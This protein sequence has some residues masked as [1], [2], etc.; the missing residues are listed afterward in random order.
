M[1]KSTLD[2]TLTSVPD[3]SQYASLL[4]GLVWEDKVTKKLEII[5]QSLSQVEKIKSW[6]EDCAK[7]VKSLQ[8]MSC[9]SSIS[10]KGFVELG[11]GLFSP[12][13]QNLLLSL[14]NL[15]PSALPTLDFP[16][17]LSDQ[18]GSISSFLKKSPRALQFTLQAGNL[19]S[20]TFNFSVLSSRCLLYSI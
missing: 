16:N 3:L 14:L 20:N 10:L 12:T 8:S 9:Q 4:S 13:M 1:T 5:Q 15:S 2:K 11:R 18:L 19:P 17:S 7:C 6:D